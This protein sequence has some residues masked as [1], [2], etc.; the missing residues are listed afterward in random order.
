MAT[1]P[2]RVVVVGGTGNISGALVDALAAAGH[3]VTVFVRGQRALDLPDGVGVI[4]GDRN[5]REAFEQTMREGGFDVAF[6]LICWGPEDAESDVRAFEG[7]GH[8]FQTSTVCTI[9]G[10]LAE[11]PAT[12]QTPLRPVGAYGEEKVRAD[13][14][15]ATAHRE[16]GFPVTVLKPNHTWGP[17]MPVVR[18][19]GLDPHWLDRLRAGKPLLIADDGSRRWQLCHV[20]DAVGAYVGLVGRE[21]AI[22][23]TYIVTAPEPITWLEYHR[24]I[25]DA[26]G[27]ELNLLSAPADDLI[28]LWPEATEILAEQS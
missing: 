11:L 26:L 17:K 23:E 1:D 4:T 14:V 7:V 13:A 25:A 15:F 10:E 12:E 9:G 24:Q 20:E 8:F 2:Q 18:Q 5:D 16:R 21:E 28:R 3:D 22:G 27:V 19:L 6:D